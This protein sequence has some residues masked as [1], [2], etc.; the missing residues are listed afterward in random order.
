MNSFSSLYVTAG[1]VTQALTTTPVKFTGF[2]T[3]G[4]GMELAGPGAAN[5]SVVSVLASD[6]ITVKAGG[7]Y[8]ACAHVDGSSSA[9]ADIAITLRKGST[10]IPQGRSQA[11]FATGSVK[12]TL[13]FTVPFTTTI[14][15][16]DVNVSLYIESS[17]GVNIT[18]IEASLT[19]IRLY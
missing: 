11:N 15:E 10:V 3:A 9:A 1:A 19:I 6:Y 14:A 18:A 13:A 12:Q 17:T 7:A 5:L 2:D 8:L 4:P 16:G